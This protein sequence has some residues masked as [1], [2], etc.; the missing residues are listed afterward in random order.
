MSW[1][2]ILKADELPKMD[3]FDFEP[4]MSFITDITERKK[5]SYNQMKEVFDEAAKSAK[6]HERQNVSLLWLDVRPTILTGFDKDEPMFSSVEM[7]E[8]KRKLAK[9]KGD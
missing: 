9:Y 2:N 8:V 1:E 4:D 7:R 3:I 5:Y 6:G